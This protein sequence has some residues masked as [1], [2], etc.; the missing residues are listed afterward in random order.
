M[1]DECPVDFSE[2]DKEITFG[3]NMLKHFQFEPGYVNM[4][5]ASYGAVPKLVAQCFDYWHSRAESNPDRWL[6]YEV[7]PRLEK[8]A[9]I[10]AKHLKVEDAKD[11]AFIPNASSGINAVLRSLKLARNDVL[12]Y[13]SEAY[14]SVKFAV[15]HTAQLA[16]AKSVELV[17]KYPFTDAE[18]IDSLD[19]AL[20][21]YTS[22]VKLVVVSHVSSVP[23]SL[24]P[25]KKLIGL[26]RAYNVPVLIDGAHGLGQLPL[27]LYDLDPDFYVTNCH[28]WFYASRGSALIYVRKNFQANMHPVVISWN[29]NN[30]FQ[31]EFHQQGT[32]DYSAF[33][34]VPAALEFRR[35]LGEEKI[36]DYNRRL[37][38]YAAETLSRAWNTD[39]LMSGSQNTLDNP[40][41]AVV[42]VRLPVN[43]SIVVHT[44]VERL[45]LSHRTF[46]ATFVEPANRWYARIS[47]QIY[48]E[49]SDYD[50]LAADV[51]E[52]KRLLEVPVTNA[53]PYCLKETVA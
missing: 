46:M 40:L 35:R 26:G 4:N 3:H 8:A 15:Q 37:A 14:G 34:T 11:V 38:R 44:I 7:M 53:Y 12:I 45:M 29:Y 42:N 18:I 51:L 41:L 39:V 31:S 1:V 49:K 5:H 33:L 28:K 27:D 9:A 52:M 17:I 2:L 19:S 21:N 32:L 48:N 22:R 30:G 10:M 43:D 24:I 47:A 50:R 23:A 25:V 13:F 16:G 6:R 36:L 20:R